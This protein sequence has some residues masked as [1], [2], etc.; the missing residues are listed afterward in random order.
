TPTSRSVEEARQTF[1]DVLRGAPGAAADV[2]AMN[3]AV[4]FHVIGAEDDLAAAFERAR[5]LLAGGAVWTTFERA[6]SAAT[7]G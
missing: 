5:S 6:R 2:V 1:V 7:R 3:A 4:V